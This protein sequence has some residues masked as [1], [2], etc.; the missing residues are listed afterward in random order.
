MKNKTHRL[1][2]IYFL[3]LS[4]I[5]ILVVASFWWEGLDKELK[6]ETTFSETNIL[7]SNVYKELIDKIINDSTKKLNLNEITEIIENH[8]YVKVARVSRHYP[9]KLIVEIIERTPIAIVNK[10]PMIFLDEESYVLPEMGNLNDYNL[11]ILS[12]FNTDSGLYPNGMQALS[13]KVI[14]CTSIIKQLKNRY[15]NLYDNLSEL[16]ITS[17][18]EIELILA[19][20]P[21][22]IYLGNKNIYD[23]IHILKEFENK[24]KPNSISNFNYLDFRYENQ[25]IANNRKS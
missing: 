12:N 24:L 1:I 2:L 11:P 15:T 3:F 25:I 18:N 22:H 8:P 9:S 14:E 16:K 6:I 19:D 13:S 10:N 5:S 7:S 20:H 21:T 23:R 4:G 17:D